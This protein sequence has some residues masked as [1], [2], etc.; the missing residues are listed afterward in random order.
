MEPANLNP[1]PDDELEAFLRLAPAPLADHGFS[2]R[3]VAA[4]PAP[5]RRHSSRMWL[6][7]AGGVTGSIVA[8]IRGA[9]WR[10]V[11]ESSDELRRAFASLSGLANEPWCV[12]AVVISVAAAIYVLRRP[13][14]DYFVT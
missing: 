1:N 10:A 2:A 12:L 3:V 14:G 9:S 4:L 6:C 5:S 8:V 11:T 13:G 7:I